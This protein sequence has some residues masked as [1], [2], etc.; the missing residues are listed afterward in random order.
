MSHRLAALLLAIP[1]LAAAGS[2]AAIEVVKLQVT[3]QGRRY[4]VE[5]E[6]Q[7][8]ADPGAVMTVL[9]DFTQYP[10]LDSRILA[11]R[12]AG[13]RDGKPRLYTRVQIGRAHV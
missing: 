6:A 11:A 13:T 1:A 10:H 2:A 3:E 7:L 4:V 5:F 9:T 12:L 8:A